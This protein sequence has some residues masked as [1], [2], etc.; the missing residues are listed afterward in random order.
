MFVNALPAAPM[1]LRFAQDKSRNSRCLVYPERQRGIGGSTA[2]VV[3]SL[4]AAPMMLRF[5]QD[6]S[7]SV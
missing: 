3:K 5:A 1:I 7:R 4:P 6:K 2:T